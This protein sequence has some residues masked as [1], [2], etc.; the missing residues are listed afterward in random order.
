[1][2]PVAELCNGKDDDCD[3]VIDNGIAIG[4][5][6]TKDYDATTYPGAR[7]KGQCQPGVSE[8]NTSTGTV[9]CK[10]GVGPAPEVCDGLD[11]D[12]DGQVD[13][14][15]NAPDGINGTANPGDPSQVVGADCGLNKGVCK[16]G[17]WACVAGALQCVGGVLPQVETCNCQDDD[18]DGFT[19][20]DPES[21]TS[22]PSLCSTG[23]ACVGYNN[24]CQCAAPCGSG[25]FLCPTG[26]FLCAS[27]ELSNT[28][29][30]GTAGPRCVIDGCGDCSKKTVKDAQGNTVCAPAGATSDGGVPAPECTCK[31]N[32]C[33]H[34]CFGVSCVTPVVCTNFG[35]N[36]GKCVED[37][38]WNLPCAAGQ[39]CNG[40]SCVEDP[41][42]TATCQAGE[43][44]KP[45]ADFTTFRCTKSCASVTCAANEACVEGICVATGCPAPC[46]NGQV[47]AGSD[48]GGCVATK[49]TPDTCPNGS[50]CNPLTGACGNNPCE[51]VL[52]PSDQEHCELGDCVSNG[53]DAGTGDA[54]GGAGGS[55]GKDSGPG[56]AGGAVV[57]GSAGNH[58]TPTD[59][60][61]GTWGL[62]TGGG[63]CACETAPGTGRTTTTA[64]LGLLA[65]GLIGR[66]RRRRWP[67]APTETAN[68]SRT[69]QNG[70]AR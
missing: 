29:T 3:T 28:Q 40:G 65:L 44:C 43:V 45:S 2:G 15:G 11:N 7:D 8:C 50:Y 62:A 25:E 34:P 27:V 13:E 60:P 66:V 12:C 38:C 21:G 17:H 53:S 37:N 47:C 23:K 9:N 33:H 26:G 48:A 24:N 68:T 4:T 30:P 6:C 56:G 1:M 67:L 35:A 69:G 64:A 46:D 39:A 16:P 61:K 42:K 5:S 58:G 63:G 59:T 18:C 57:D 19:D 52:C 31:E 20:E 10:N 49:C 51:G 55:G 54:A 32:A 70:G 22:E 14:V 41:C 36:A